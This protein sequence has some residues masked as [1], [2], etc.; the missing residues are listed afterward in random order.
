MNIYSVLITNIIEVVNN[1]HLKN[2][3]LLTVGVSIAAISILGFVIYFNNRSS[4]T[5]KTFAALSASAM[6]WAA[7]NYLSYQTNNY[8]ELTLWL[9]RIVLFFAVWFAYYLFKLTYVFPGNEMVFP[10]WYRHYLVPFTVFT[11]LLTLSPFVFSGISQ[12]SAVGSVSHATVLPGIGVFGIAVFIFIFGSF[13]NLIKKLRAAKKDE[14]PKYRLMLV[15]TIITFGLIITFNFIF[16]IALFNVKYIP[17]GGLFI[18]P[19]VAFTAYAIFKHRLFNVKNIVT[20]V[21]TFFLCFVTLVEIVFAPDTT[22]ML[23][24]IAV[25]FVALMISIKLVQNTF[26]LEAANE[27]K[28]EFMS[29]ASHELRS[30]ITSIKNY[31]ELL[32]EGGMGKLNPDIKDGVQKILVSANG[33]IALIAQYLNKAKMELNQ[34]TYF[35]TVFDIA[36]TV[37]AAVDNVQVNAEQKG[38]FV[39][40]KLDEKAVVNVRADEG[41]TREVIG[42]VLDNAIKFTKIG[43]VLVTVEDGR[44]KVLIKIADTGEGITKEMMPLLFK[45]FSKNEESKNIMGSGLGLF[46]SRTFIDA[47]KGRLWAESEG[48]G[49]GSQFYIE[50]P[51]T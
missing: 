7:V 27:K 37:R 35:V 21:F 47:M 15:G 30:P 34:F 6:I 51:K 10:K 14:K 41:K 22:Q 9:L 40:L 12:I 24:R 19:F 1:L 28:A 3:D 25:F 31:S 36:K 23:L 11:S 16:P 8:A 46:L 5:N 26:E 38:V 50:L 32:L 44:D 29:F 20:A 4:V 43:G 42:N 33:A 17:L 48:E 13:F 2:L 18:F 39:T 49:R 45:K